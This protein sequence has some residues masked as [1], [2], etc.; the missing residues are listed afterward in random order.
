MSVSILSVLTGFICGVIFSFFKLLIPAPSVFNG[1]LGII[2]I[3]T[4]YTVV[5]LILKY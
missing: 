3:W 4:G 5:K 2:G 1:I